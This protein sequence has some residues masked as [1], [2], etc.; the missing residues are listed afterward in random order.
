M[1]CQEAVAILVHHR[2]DLQAR[3]VRHAAVFGSVVRGEARPDSDIDILI[4]LDPKA[5]LDLFAFVGLTRY[6]AKL[7][8][9]PVDVVDR[10]A[11]RPHARPSAEREAVHAF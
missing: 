11:L 1:D 3:G 9:N 2:D 4:D 6:I 8:P 5:E 10:E 7:F